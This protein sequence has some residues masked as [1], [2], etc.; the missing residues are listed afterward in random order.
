MA[1]IGQGR[2]ATIGACLGVAVTASL[3]LGLAAALFFAPAAALVALPTAPRLLIGVAAFALLLPGIF[4][5]TMLLVALPAAIVERLGL[6]ESLRRSAWLTEGHRRKLLLIWA[7]TAIAG[8]TC[9]ARWAPRVTRW[10][11]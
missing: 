6:I 8:L 9:A 7:T 5:S 3:P 4:V 10:G 1:P 2:R 11:S